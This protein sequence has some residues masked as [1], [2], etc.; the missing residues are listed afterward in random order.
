MNEEQRGRISQPR[1]EDLTFDGMPIHPHH[2]HILARAG[3]ST[4]SEIESLTEE[5]FSQR[6]DTAF[7]GIDEGRMRR[8]INALK[9]KGILF[10]DE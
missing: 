6:V 8:C 3:F 10:S 2:Q 1:E 5:E 9:R 7:G 4:I